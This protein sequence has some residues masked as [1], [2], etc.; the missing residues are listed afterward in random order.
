MGVIDILIRNTSYYYQ[1]LKYLLNR[2]L[3]SVV[4]YYLLVIKEKK[5]S[6][7]LKLPFF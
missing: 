6:L 4:K 3:L 2:L 7:N 1:K 5:G